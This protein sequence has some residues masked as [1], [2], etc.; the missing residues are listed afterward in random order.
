MLLLICVIGCMMCNHFAD[1]KSIKDELQRVLCGRRLTDFIEKLCKGCYA[2]SYV[3]QINKSMF[4]ADF[5]CYSYDG[6]KNDPNRALTL[7]PVA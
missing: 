1:T 2:G 4:H 3:D 6:S 7:E 5:I